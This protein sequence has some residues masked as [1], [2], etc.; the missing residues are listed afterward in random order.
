[1][2]V[3]KRDGS[4]VTFHSK[5]VIAAV[6]AANEATNPSE[7]SKEQIQDISEYIEFK[8]RKLK[9]S[10]SVEEIQDGKQHSC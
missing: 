8:C 10:V 9:R 6:K 4:E 3:I 5:K 2:K 7:L 1:M